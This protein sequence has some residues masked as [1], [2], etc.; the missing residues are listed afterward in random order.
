MFFKDYEVMTVACLLTAFQYNF[1]DQ[2]WA[3]FGAILGFVS[4]LVY[5]R[6]GGTYQSVLD[7]AFVGY[8]ADEPYFE[9]V[10]SRAA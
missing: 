3:A 7:E 2:P 1:I 5:H 9:A 4:G 10:H 6:F 8:V